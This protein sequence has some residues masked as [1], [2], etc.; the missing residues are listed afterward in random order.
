[1]EELILTLLRIG[2]ENGFEVYV[3][4]EVSG[5][6]KNLEFQVIPPEALPYQ[7]SIARFASVL[8][9]KSGRV[10]AHFEV[11]GSGDV[12]KSTFARGEEIHRL[13]PESER[14]LVVPHG[15]VRTVRQS[16]RKTA[17]FW[18]VAS[19]DCILHLG[20]APTRQPQLMALSPASAHPL[21]LQIESKEDILDSADNVVAFKLKL[22]CPSDVLKRVRPGHFLQVQINTEGRR[23]FSEYR[24]GDS[25]STLAGSPSRDLKKLEFLRIPLSIHRIYYESFEPRVLR[26][27]S[28]GF[29]PSVFWQWIEPGDMKYLDLLIRLV[30]DGTRALHSLEEGD[31]VNAMGPLGKPIDF[32]TDFENAVLISGGVGLASLYPI[33]YHLRARGYK[34]VLFA[35]ARDRRTL[36]DKSGNVLPDFAEMGVEC[37]VT[38]EVKENKLV[39]HLVSEWFGSYEHERLS[40]GCRIYSCGPWLMLKEV[41][42]I[43]SQR[44]LPCTVLVDKLML[45]GVGAC[46]SCVVETRN[47]EESSTH[48]THELTQMVRSCVEGPA[49][50]SRDIVWD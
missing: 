5:L 34:V 27:R 50:E 16:L 39:T 46:M 9:L 25:Y 40:G 24:S 1:M 20:E 10:H 3:S 45:C 6:I 33:A 18:H 13:W 12:P 21:K 14:V 42:K 43:A 31:T 37:H 41:N 28:R 44:D 4:P 2:Q 38:D 29:L 19:Y 35:G 8:W 7:D 15:A 47:R 48:K 11:E 30:G 23:Y 32:P 26:N 17:G 22:L 36:E 49:F